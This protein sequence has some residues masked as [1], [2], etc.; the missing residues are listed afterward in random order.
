[1]PAGCL[2]WQP[3]LRSKGNIEKDDQFSKSSLIVSKCQFERQRKRNRNVKIFY[4]LIATF[5][6]WKQ[7]ALGQFFSSWRKLWNTELRCICRM[8]EGLQIL[9]LWHSRPFRSPGG[10]SN[11][12]QW[13]ASPSRKPNGQSRPE[14]LVYFSR[15]SSL[16]KFFYLCD[17][18]TIGVIWVIKGLEGCWA[19]YSSSLLWVIVKWKRRFNEF[20]SKVTSNEGGLQS[21]K[22]LANWPWQAEPSSGY[23]QVGF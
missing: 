17:S 11:P 19:W 15:S 1:M 8:S 5:Q 2:H 13:S 20:N 10:G 21:L 14:R 4:S 6:N 12:G 23:R 18:G 3:Q 7:T 16:R 9:L 22:C